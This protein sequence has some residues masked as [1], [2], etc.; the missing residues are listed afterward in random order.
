MNAAMAAGDFQPTKS[1]D[2]VC[3]LLAALAQHG[4]MTHAEIAQRLSIPKSSVTG[5]INTLEAHHFIARDESGRRYMLGPQILTLAQQYMAG[6]DLARIGQPVVDELMRESGESTALSIASGPDIVVVAKANCDQPL[7]RTMQLGERAPM[8]ATAGGKA[9]LA[10]LPPAEIE[11]L[12]PKD[13]PPVTPRTLK[14]RRALLKELAEIR[15]GQLAYSR[16]ELI[17]GIFA[18]GVPVLGAHG[19]PVASLSVAVPSVRFTPKHE[20]HIA[21]AMRRAADTLSGRLGY[22][23]AT[24]PG[25]KHAA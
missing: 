17:P 13:L 8:Y 4:S 11:R 6:L 21:T 16:E 1:A 19:A 25:A 2:R 7:Q 12:V 9:I 22:R 3:Q 18:V 20:A 24:V 15:A 23:K 14:S 10:F 5:L